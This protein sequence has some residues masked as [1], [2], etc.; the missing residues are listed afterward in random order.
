MSF[1]T[2]SIT[3]FPLLP[4]ASDPYANFHE[5]FPQLSFEYSIPLFTGGEHPPFPSIFHTSWNVHFRVFRFLFLK[6]ISA[7]T[8]VIISWQC[9]SSSFFSVSAT[10]FTISSSFKTNSSWISDFMSYWCNCLIVFSISFNN[11]WWID[12]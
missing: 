6:S 7:S 4:K 10:Y 8:F 9:F 5:H 11:L 12:L 3:S 1:A 2:P